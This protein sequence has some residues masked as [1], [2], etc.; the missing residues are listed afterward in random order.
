MMMIT[1]LIAVIEIRKQSVLSRGLFYINDSLSHKS[2]AVS[3]KREMELAR[4][5]ERRKS[6]QQKQLW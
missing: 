3:A 1:I 2:H 5:M 4:K 6:K